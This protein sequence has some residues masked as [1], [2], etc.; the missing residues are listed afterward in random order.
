MRSLRAWPTHHVKL[1]KLV[2]T[3]AHV[4]ATLAWQRVLSSIHRQKV[5]QFWHAW[6]RIA[7]PGWKKRR[8]QT[9]ARLVALRNASVERANV[10]MR[11]LRAWPTHHVKLDRK[12]QM[13]R[14]Q[15][16]QAHQLDIRSQTLRKV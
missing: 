12:M 10:L 15:S 16:C 7:P 1:D 4:A 11:S 3:H 2:L 6:K 13:E 14:Q 9:A 5:R 8:C